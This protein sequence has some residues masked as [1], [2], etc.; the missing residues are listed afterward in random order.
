MRTKLTITIDQQLLPRAKRYA[1]SRGLSLSRVIENALREMG[2]DS[3]ASFSQRWRGKFLP[4]RRDDL[5]Y[6][7]LAKKYM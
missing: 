4:A 1:R 3:T 7:A 5:R 2:A 6:R